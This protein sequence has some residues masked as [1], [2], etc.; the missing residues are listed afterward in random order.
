[1]EKLIQSNIVNLYDTCLSLPRIS[2]TLNST[3]TK[4]KLK[5]ISQQ[6]QENIPRKNEIHLNLRS[7]Y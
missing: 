6:S 2:I 3:K 4:K 7:N 5:K 1:M